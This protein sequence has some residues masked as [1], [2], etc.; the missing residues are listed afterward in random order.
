M[1]FNG[2]SLALSN[3]FD[4][5]SKIVKALYVAFEPRVYY[6]LDGYT[7]PYPIRAVNIFASSS[8][9]VEWVYV[10]DTKTFM[11]LN[12]YARDVIAESIPLPILSLEIIRDERVSYDLTD[13]IEGVRI[14]QAP[15]ERFIPSVSHIVRAWSIDSHIIFDRAIAFMARVITDT[16]ITATH[17]ID[18]F[19]DEDDAVEE[20]VNADLDADAELLAGL[21]RGDPDKATA[22]AEAPK[23]E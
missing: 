5:T 20:P 7:T 1:A 12:M 18:E 11:P 21:I 14:R 9:E 4:I 23:I 22:A 10:A 15:G 13:F 17:D 8:A 16:G 19:V 6:F 2:L 3:G